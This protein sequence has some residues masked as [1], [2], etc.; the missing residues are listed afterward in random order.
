MPV[1]SYFS[2]RRRRADRFRLLAALLL[3]LFL[4]PGQA[5]A[6]ALAWQWATAS[7]TADGDLTASRSVTDAA[8]NVYV[9]GVMTSAARFGSTLLL[10][11]GDGDIFVTKLN[12]AGTFQWAVQVGGPEREVTGGIAVDT[13]GNLY[14]A[15]SFLS[16]QVTFGTTTLTLATGYDGFV[17]KL[18]PA[19]TWQWAVSTGSTGSET[20]QDIALDAS[21]NIYLTG[22]FL[23]VTGGVGSL[24]LP[25]TSTSALGDPDVFVAM[26]NP[27]GVW[28]WA[29]GAGG[30]DR[31]E[32]LRLAVDETGNVS[33]IG[34][35]WG[36]RVTVG[37]TTLFGFATTGMFVTRLSPGG[38]WRWGQRVA[39]IAT[40]LSSD[41]SAGIAVDH[42]GNA[43][44]TGGFN[45]ARATFGSTVLV[46]ALLS[47][48][49]PMDVFVAKIDS[50]GAWQ[51]AVRG[52]GIGGENS[53]A[54]AI[55]AFDNLYVTGG[56]DGATTTFGAIT[57]T[58]SGFQNHDVFV[59]KLSPAGSWL[60]ATTAGG[61]AK[62][63]G[64]SIS[65]TTN[66]DLVVS[67]LFT[68]PVCTFGP[69]SLIHN[70]SAPH[71]FVSRLSQPLGLASDART[72]TVGVFPNPAHETL[73]LTGATGTTALLLDARGQRV[74]TRP[75]QQGAATF[76]LRGLSAGLYVVRAG[77][78]TRRVVV[79]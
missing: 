37:D 22:Y 75:L 65:L 73:R 76:D 33:M 52:G 28:Q 25:N 51:W 57:L 72:S 70:G 34:R 77:N 13:A 46:N 42:S 19:G 47:A 44:V 14:V 69:A 36:T 40:Y 59:A 71:L 38:V 66:N 3:L 18:S 27:A 49:R 56:Y 31:D 29:A 4:R 62:E 23:G 68:S 20:V 9:T 74:R 7:G 63:L 26:L 48:P 16:P 32:G 6:Q 10:H 78:T 12:S 15:G 53:T 64:Q 1:L 54:L 2:I 39:G 35:T 50:T 45:T 55:D 11:A 17:A 67:G 21:G 24:S 8:G 79:E 60:W 58:Q 61:V 41:P 43:Y 5:T 30:P